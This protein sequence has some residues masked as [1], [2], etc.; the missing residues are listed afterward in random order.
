MSNSRMSGTPVGKT[1]V[2]FLR[3]AVERH[4]SRDALL[5]KPAFRCQRWSYSRLWNES[6]RVA[7]LLQRRGLTK[8]DQVVLWAP[9]LPTGSPLS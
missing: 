9:T 4:G 3:G 1:V 6:G 2:D 8:G 5:F 7:T